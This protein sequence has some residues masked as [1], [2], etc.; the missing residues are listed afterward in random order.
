[1][2]RTI[3]TAPYTYIIVAALFVVEEV[4]TNNMS[5]QI[6]WET[7]TSKNGALFKVGRP[8]TEGVIENEPGNKNN[9][10][11]IVNWPVAAVAAGW[12]TTTEDVQKTAAISRYMLEDTT[13]DDS[14]YGYRYRLTFS[15]TKHYNYYF[16]DKTGD[17]YQNNTYLNADHTISYNSA[18]P[19]IV[20]VVGV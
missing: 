16:S 15:N 20:Y 1:L 4:H 17:D 2:L 13:G 11:I 12:V 19:T 7:A 9:F 10:G 14:R 6:Q 5:D 3:T 8:K 18:D